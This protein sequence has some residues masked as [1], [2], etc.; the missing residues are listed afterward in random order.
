MPID[1]QLVRRSL[2][3][4]ET[5]GRVTAR[6]IELAAKDQGWREGHALS[7]WARNSLPV[8]IDLAV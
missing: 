1:R 4:L 6:V 7:S 3:D 8:A 2:C 5:I